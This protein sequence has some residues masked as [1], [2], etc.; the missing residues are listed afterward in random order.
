MREKGVRGESKER[1]LDQA[2]VLFAQKGFEGVSVREITRAAGC[3]LASVNYYFGNKENLYVEVFQA[4][5]V[6]RA[7]R[8][9][10]DFRQALKGPEPLSLSHIIQSLSLAFLKGPLSEEERRRHHQLMAREMAQPTAALEMLAEQIMRPFFR[11]LTD[12]LRPLAPEG[13]DERELMLGA[14]GIF[15]MVLYFSFGRV[16][17]TRLLGCEYDDALRKRLSEHIA[18]FSIS[19]LEG[20]K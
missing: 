17:V 15:A 1:L 2:E 5:W 12:M 11:E 20:L 4:R 16:A 3:N 13:L 9:H 14:M 18:G 8:I 6:P 10:D 19:G 7:R